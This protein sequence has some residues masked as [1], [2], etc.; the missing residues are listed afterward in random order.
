MACLCCAVEQLADAAD[1]NASLEATTTIRGDIHDDASFGGK[2]AERVV[3]ILVEC[4]IA[5]GI[6][7]NGNVLCAM[8][9]AD[10]CKYQNDNE[11]GPWARGCVYESHKWP[12]QL[13]CSS[14]R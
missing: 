8:R 4:D 3:Q 12:T 1:G 5:I 11:E 10:P 9:I 14:C 7:D 6:I 2:D 13:D